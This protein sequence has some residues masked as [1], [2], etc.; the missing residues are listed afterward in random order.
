MPNAT[1]LNTKGSDIMKRFVAVVFTLTLLVAAMVL[2]ASAVSNEGMY[3][4]YYY[5]AT[6]SSATL[7]A[8]THMTYTGSAL[9][10][11]N[12]T[13]YY[14]NT[15]TNAPNNITLSAPPQKKS[16]NG[17]ITIPAGNAITSVNE[18]YYVSGTSVTSLGVTL[19]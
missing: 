8:T 5:T 18:Y 9:I 7:T 17:S 15:A 3:N 11:C 4:G 10:H 14:K 13:V 1:I 16:T 12:G 2:P 19:P 6:L